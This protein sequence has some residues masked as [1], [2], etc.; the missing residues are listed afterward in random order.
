MS[1]QVQDDVIFSE[2]FIYLLRYENLS[3]KVRKRKM[4]IACFWFYCLKER[5]LTWK[6][7]L[8][9]E[10][11]RCVCEFFLLFVSSFL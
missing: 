9:N 3:R 8:Q 4:Y 1:N 7:I 6:E 5:R 2:L 10:A 11:L